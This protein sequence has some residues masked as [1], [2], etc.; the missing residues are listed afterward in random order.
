MFKNTFTPNE[1]GH[2]TNKMMQDKLSI[3][4]PPH[5][6]NT[7]THMEDEYLSKIDES[8]S[9]INEAIKQKKKSVDLLINTNTL[10]SNNL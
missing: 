3:V 9:Q 4:S 2:S 10:T 8:S 6:A 1:K 7:K 5:R